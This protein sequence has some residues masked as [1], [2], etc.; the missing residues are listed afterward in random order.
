MCHLQN[1]KNILNSESVRK[2]I[3]ATRKEKH[4][5]GDELSVQI[6]KGKAYI[7][8]IESGKIKYISTDTLKQF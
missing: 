6:G 8:Q 1:N 4:I 3:K 5:R 2:Y 7:S